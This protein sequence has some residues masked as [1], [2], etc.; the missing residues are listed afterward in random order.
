MQR[1]ILLSLLS[2]VFI[3]LSAQS[4][5]RAGYIITNSMDTIHGF[6]DHRGEIRNMRICSFKESIEGPEKEFLPGEIYGYRFN[7]GKFYISKE[8]N[9]EEVNDIVFVEFLLMGISNL[10]YYRNSSYNAYFIETEDKELLELRRSIDE[11]QRDGRV[12]RRS[13]DSYQGVLNYAFSDYPEIRNEIFKTDFSHKSLIQITRRYHDYK[14]SDE[15]CIIFEKRLPVLR[16]EIKPMIGYALSGI[17]FKNTQVDHINF[18]MSSSSFA[19]IALNFIAPR[20]NEKTSFLVNLTFNEDYY[21]GSLSQGINSINSYYHIY[22]TNLISSFSLKY[23]YPGNQIK[24]ELF[25]GLFGKTILK[26]DTEFYTERFSSYNQRVRTTRLDDESF[27]KFTKGVTG[28]IGIEYNLL[29]KLRAFSNFSYYYGISSQVQ[30]ESI[31]TSYR[32]STGLTF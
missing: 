21:Y 12:Y 10:Y 8:I 5:F 17:T 13:N 20:W 24:P 3:S 4:D 29:K 9:T 28:G 30:I 22:N 18:Q 11:I 16:V 6:I 14:C 27:R 31:F 23:T 15:A 32:F 1:L 26:S 2:L 19:G 25:V 7:S